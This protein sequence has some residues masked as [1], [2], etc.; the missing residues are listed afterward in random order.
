MERST[1]HSDGSGGRPQRQVDGR[2]HDLGRGC[3]AGV[4][5]HDD[6]VSRLG[7]ALLCFALLSGAL[8]L[9]LLLQL[10]GAPRADIAHSDAEIL[11]RQREQQGKLGPVIDLDFSHLKRK[12]ISEL[13]QEGK[14]GSMI[15]PPIQPQDSKPGAIVERRVRETTSR[16]RA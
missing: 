16:R 14:A 13:P 5:Q 3:A 8:L 6:R 12:S 4:H 7:P 2:R 15:L 10:F 9:H 11:A 1:S